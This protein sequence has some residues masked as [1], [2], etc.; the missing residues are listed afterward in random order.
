M[1]MYLAK[2]QPAVDFKRLVLLTSRP[3]PNTKRL[4]DA[5]PEIVIQYMDREVSLERAEGFA[6]AKNDPSLALLQAARYCNLMVES[7]S[8]LSA[9]SASIY[10]KDGYNG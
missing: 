6:S 3:M 7:S 1:L 8:D 5:H 2:R 10:R 9:N 4:L